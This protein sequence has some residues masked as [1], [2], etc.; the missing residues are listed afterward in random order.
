MPLATR[1]ASPSVMTRSGSN[2][3]R[4]RRPPMAGVVPIGLAMISPSPRKHSATPITHA[5]ARLPPSLLTAPPLSASPGRTA[6][7]SANARLR[8]GIPGSRPLR[9]YA[10]HLPVLGVIA[11][12]EVL[13]L[14]GGPQVGF[15]GARGVLLLERLVAAVV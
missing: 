15:P 10:D 13:R 12:V 4:A 7:R 9:S 1:S 3:S 11:A 2:T 5:S 6:P 8:A 14:P